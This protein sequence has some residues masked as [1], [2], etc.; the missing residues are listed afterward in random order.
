MIL[1]ISCDYVVGDPDGAPQADLHLCVGQLVEQL[2][3]GSSGVSPRHGGH[4]LPRHTGSHCLSAETAV[5]ENVSTGPRVVPLHPLCLCGI[6]CVEG[7]GDQTLAGPDTGPQPPPPIVQQVTTLVTEFA[8]GAKL[9]DTG[10]L[11]AGR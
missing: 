2:D 1:T 4:L 10:N 5:T 9:L 3:V 11:C 6:V 7:V 8:G